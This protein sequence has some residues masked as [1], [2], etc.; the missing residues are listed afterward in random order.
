MIQR[1]GRIENFFVIL[2]FL[3]P[4]YSSHLF[5]DLSPIIHGPEEPKYK[6]SLSGRICSISPFL[7]LRVCRHLSV[8]NRGASVGRLLFVVL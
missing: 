4:M 5:R 7:L 6:N 8:S 3:H 1:H 2:L